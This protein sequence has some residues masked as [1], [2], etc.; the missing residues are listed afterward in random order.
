MAL[1]H[2]PKIITDNLAL[3]ID[4]GNIKSYSGSGTNVNDLVGST[5]FTLVNPSYYSY[6]GTSMSLDIDRTNYPTAE[7]GGYIEKVGTTGGLTALNYLHNDHTTEIWF[8]A[9]NRD[10]YDPSNTS[11][12]Y[13]TNSGLVLFNG[14]HSGWYF[15]TS[16]YA[17]SIWGN[18]GTSN[19]VDSWN[20]SDT[21][22][23]VWTQLVA[24]RNGSN[25]KLYKNG[26]EKLTDTINASLLAANV[27]TPSANN[28]RIGTATGY[29]PGSFTWFSDITFS[30][31]RMYKKALTASEIEQNFNALRGRFSI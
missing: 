28:I 19:Q 1:A 6:D 15:S 24:V 18:D 13:E 30:N 21:E 8:K 25:I 10:P 27:S 16:A 5:N 12:Q 26:I 20:F 3:L 2:S 17:Y 4:F 14:F 22:E 9:D 23:G 7:T 31:L 29:T 11:G